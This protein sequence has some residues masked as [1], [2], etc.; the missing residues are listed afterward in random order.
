MKI[1]KRRLSYVTTGVADNR[2]S[3]INNTAREYSNS[4]ADRCDSLRDMDDNPEVSQ[5][6]AVLRAF[7]APVLP[8][9]YRP[10]VSIVN[11]SHSHIARSQ[12]LVGDE[13]RLAISS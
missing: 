7:R 4:F 8:I 2:A 6:S 10:T 3:K 1:G 12:Y 9:P 5:F 11:W 13:M